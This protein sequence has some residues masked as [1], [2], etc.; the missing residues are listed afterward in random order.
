MLIDTPSALLFFAGSYA[1]MLVV[2]GPNFLVVSRASLAG[3]D[4]G[5]AAALGVAM[6]ATANAAAVVA[7][8]Y[9]LSGVIASGGF[10]VVQMAFCLAYAVLLLR[11]GITCLKEARQGNAPRPA[12]PPG[13]ERGGAMR[14]SAERG[15]AAQFRL[16][17]LTAASNPMSLTFFLGA[18]AFLMAAGGREAVLAS[19]LLVFSVAALWFGILAFLFSTPLSRRLYLRTRVTVDLLSGGLLIVAGG[20][21]LARVIQRASGLLA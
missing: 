6:G 1:A 5:T 7:C 19:P 9:V 14:E 16:G 17:L 11:T 20:V 2:P 10:G 3:R 21:V 15:V 8:L 13:A 18:S 12:Q 4:A